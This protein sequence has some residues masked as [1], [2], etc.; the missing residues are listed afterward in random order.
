MDSTNYGAFETGPSWP[1]E[2]AC[3]DALPQS[4]GARFTA[5]MQRSWCARRTVNPGLL[6]LSMLRDEVRRR[7]L[8]TWLN[9]GAG[10]SSFLAAEADAL[11]DFIAEQLPNASPELAVCRLE[12]L[13]L[14]AHNS[15][16]S[17]CAPDPAPLGPQ[18]IVRRAPYAGLVLFYGKPDPVL[19]ALLPR[20]PLSAWSPDVTALLV[21]PGSQPFCRIAS[22]HEHKLWMRL[23]LPTAV[24]V[25]VR[26]GSPRDVIERML[27]IGALEFA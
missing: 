6:A 13:T 1:E 22:P 21:A 25:L 5:A 27:H 10:A 14:R 4:A 7:L 11:L 3:V 20:T 8:D 18:R 23:T 2:G 24:A 17:F 9:S 26:E 15:A 12:Q 19:S 16:S